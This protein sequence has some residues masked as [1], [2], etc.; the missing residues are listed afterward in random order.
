MYLSE[1]IIQGNLFQLEKHLHSTDI[2]DANFKN[3][4]EKLILSQL[5]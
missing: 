1:N 5:I 3:I 4:L 2:K